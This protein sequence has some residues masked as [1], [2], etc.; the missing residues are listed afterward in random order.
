MKKYTT[1]YSFATYDLV[2]KSKFPL[3]LP[4]FALKTHTYTHSH[5]VKLQE[6]VH[7]FRYISHYRTVLL[8]CNNFIYEVLRK[9]FTFFSCCTLS[10]LVSGI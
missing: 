8:F 3:T 1:Q 2:H 5:T 6:D 4:L 10:L 7:C 9:Y